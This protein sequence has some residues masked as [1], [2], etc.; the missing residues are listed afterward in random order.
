M[1][2]SKTAGRFLIGGAY[3]LV[4]GVA[5]L[6]LFYHLDNHLLWGDEGETAVLARNVVQFGV[7]RT[8]DG[9]NYILLHNQ[10]DENRDHVWVWSPWLQEYLA[11]GSFILFGPTTW[12]ARAPFALIGWGSLVALALVAYKIYRSHGVALTS[13]TLLGTS[14]VFLLHARQCRYYS[15]SIFGEILLVYGIHRLFAQ[16]RR[17]AG[18]AVLGLILQFYSNYIVAV[19]NLPA[20]LILAWMLRK[21]GKPALLRVAAVAGILMVA[22]LP[23]L[24]YAHPWG[25]SRAVG[26]ELLH[27]GKVW[28]YLL[29]FHF[30]FLP[31]CFL[32][33]PLFG[34]FPAGGAG[35]ATGSAVVVRWE[36][37]LLLLLV[38]FFAVILL[39]P[40]F[41]LRYLVPVFPVAC[42]L[43]AAWIF[44]YVRWRALAV[45]LI[46]VQIF[47]NALAMVTAYPFRGRH[48]FRLP[49]VEY[50]QG[51]ARPYADRFTDVLD[52]FKQEAHPKQM[53][54]SFD[55]E[56]PLRFYSQLAVIDGVLMAPPKGRLPEWILPSSASGV[57]VQDAVALPDFLK[58]FYRT[59]TISVHDSVR[60]DSIPEPDSYRYHSVQV[61]APF[62]LYRLNAGTNDQRLP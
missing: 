42:L 3:G 8:F 53:V 25:Q 45:L 44:R 24:V 34:W 56:F 11:A 58:P 48:N 1:G 49:L 21:Q 22:A 62:I 23:W 17:G 47:S 38:S 41:Y 43:A 30:H 52:F 29:E 37:F 39:A 46:A 18:L 15:I 20:L 5:L 31:L 7:P 27:L 28:D 54:L 33:L 26:G 2:D 36:R 60:G 59:I 50:V 57:V 19:A 55:P 12:A 32:L 51:L 16:N 4:L 35:P 13:V 14:E 40:G 9:T 10:R 61:R 6:L